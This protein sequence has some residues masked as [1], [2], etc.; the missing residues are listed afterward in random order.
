MRLVRDRRGQG[1]IEYLILVAL[2]AV[3]SIAVVRVVGSSVSLQYAKIAK[4]LGA[5]VEGKLSAQSVSD[6][7][8]KKKDLTN[9]LNGA[10]DGGRNRGRGDDE[11]SE[12]G[13]GRGSGLSVGF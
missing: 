9:F 1:L 10:V 4:A 12:G 11:V 6:G 2:V 13:G 5:T 7:M 8:Y 3:G